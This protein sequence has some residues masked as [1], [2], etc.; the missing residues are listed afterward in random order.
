[1]KKITPNQLSLLEGKSGGW[2]GGG[3]EGGAVLNSS[4]KI[5]G[6]YSPRIFLYKPKHF[7][8]LFIY[9][10]TL[11]YMPNSITVAALAIGQ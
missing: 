4:F 9:S 1:M 5:D 3:G 2:G 6:G 8:L 7:N 10:V 11:Y